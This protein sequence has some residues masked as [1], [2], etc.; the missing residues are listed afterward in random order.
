MLT[1]PGGGIWRGYL[2]YND[3]T[4]RGDVMPSCCPS[5]VYDPPPSPVG[6][7]L[8]DAAWPRRWDCGDWPQWLGTS[9]I[10]AD[11]AIFFSYMLIPL[12]AAWVLRVRPGLAPDRPLAVLSILFVVSCGLTHLF[13]AASFWWSGYHLQLVVKAVTALFSVATVVRIWQQRWV[14]V[15]YTSPTE[16]AAL[17]AAKEIADAATAERQKIIAE[18]N[19]VS[20]ERRQHNVRL[21]SAVTD[22]QLV[23]EL[24]LAKEDLDTL[25][26]KIAALIGGDKS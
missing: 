14:L 11:L 10:A 2:S 22:L 21:I 13:T 23:L 1:S 12:I 15:N 9:T 3:V 16:A 26:P 5:H 20:E 24:K 7:L 4:S 19:T 18:L 8:Y 6:W 17:V 25:R